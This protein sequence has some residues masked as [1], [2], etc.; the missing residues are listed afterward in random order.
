MVDYAE[1][2]QPVTLSLRIDHINNSFAPVG[3]GSGPPKTDVVERW[4]WGVPGLWQALGRRVC[5]G[6][7][8]GRALGCGVWSVGTEGSERGWCAWR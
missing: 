6:V 5:L 4:S 2:L 3:T 7:P 1:S 8:L